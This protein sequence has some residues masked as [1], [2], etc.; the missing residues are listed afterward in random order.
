MLAW[1]RG[2]HE[3][4]GLALALALGL[5]LFVRLAAPYAGAADRDGYVA[6]CTG[7]EIVYLPVG[8]DGM[9]LPDGKAPEKSDIAPLQLPCTWLG[10]YVALL[11]AL[12]MLVLPAGRPLPPEQARPDEPHHPKPRKPF[13][14][15]APPSGR[16]PT[17]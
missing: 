5:S 3:R 17:L 16:H 8:Q 10:Q 7:G 13:Q 11:P 12:A 2:L 14:S 15:Q 9:P 1:C 4:W 6:I